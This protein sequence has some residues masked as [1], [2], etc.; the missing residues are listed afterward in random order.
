MKY[1][2]VT[3]VSTREVYI[4]PKALSLE[5][6]VKHSIFTPIDLNKQSNNLK[7][8]TT[9]ELSQET[10]DF[11]NSV[12][13]INIPLFY[14]NKFFFIILQD[15]QKKNMKQCLELLEY[16]LE[17]FNGESEK[18]KNWLE[19][20]NKYLNAKPSDLIKTQE[21]IETVRKELNRI[22]FGNFI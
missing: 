7:Q 4:A 16:G 5:E 10:F 18:F 9:L 17:V 15:T 6:F 22:E 11:I 14:L 19:E 8:F 20:E 3:E 2:V 21:G 12:A 13:N 1:I